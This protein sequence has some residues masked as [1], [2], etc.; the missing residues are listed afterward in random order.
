MDDS[1]PWE[2]FIAQAREVLPLVRGY[3]RTYLDSKSIR[4][5]LRALVQ[6]YFRTARPE[7]IALGIAESELEG[8]DL[9]MQT[10]LR[11]L[12]ERTRTSAFLRLARETEPQISDLE[13]KRELQ[14]GRSSASPRIRF[15]ETGLE[16]AISKTLEEMIP[17][18][19][20][21]YRQALADL[22]DPEKVSFR[23]TA[24]ELR[25]ALREVLDHLAPDDAVVSVSGFR[26]EPDRTKP[27]MRQK[28]RFI[29]KARSVPSGSI[30]ATMDATTLVEER[31]AAL[32]RS[33][34]DRGS[35]SSHVQTTR[36]EVANMKPYVD[37]LLAELLQVHG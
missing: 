9:E 10:L 6:S 21:S 32:A 5:G 24:S 16:K 30:G 19:A 28:V 37:S 23:G 36:A 15:L 8:L 29:L 7:L 13:F 35:V 27:T 26:L 20:L 17:T 2:S 4:D 3:H 14:I 1:P 12:S 18:A 33:M 22:R 31:T 25:E 34:Y 11:M